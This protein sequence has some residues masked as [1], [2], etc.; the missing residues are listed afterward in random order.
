MGNLQ[1][2]CTLYH[3]LQSIFLLLTLLSLKVVLKHGQETPN[4]YPVPMT[5]P[6]QVHYQVHVYTA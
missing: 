5:V 2:T 1:S 3:I 4:A 6:S